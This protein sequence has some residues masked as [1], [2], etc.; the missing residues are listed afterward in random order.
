MTEK[1]L[2]E[3]QRQ[4]EGRTPS[5]VGRAGRGM[6]G[7]KSG[8]ISKPGWELSSSG[9][10]HGWRVELECLPTPHAAPQFSHHNAI[11]PTSAVRPSAM[12]GMTGEDRLYTPGR[13]G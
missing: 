6:D 13:M 12:V 7:C 8:E 10:H 1:G 3:K 11:S 9:Q 5:S 4:G 2:V